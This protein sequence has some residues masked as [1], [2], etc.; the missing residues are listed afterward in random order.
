M[1]PECPVCKTQVKLAYKG[2][3]LVDEVGNVQFIRKGCV[4]CNYIPKEGK[5]FGQG[6]S[7]G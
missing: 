2:P 4:N 7:I 6:L 5:C 1:E 3:D